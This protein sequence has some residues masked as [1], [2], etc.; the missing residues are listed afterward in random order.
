M[1]SAFMLTIPMFGLKENTIPQLQ[2]VWL[3]MS[4]RLTITK[5]VICLGHLLMCDKEV[6]EV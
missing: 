3:P 6:I 1:E 4:M 5:S 2:K